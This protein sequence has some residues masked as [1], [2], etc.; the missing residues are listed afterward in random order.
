LGSRTSEDEVDVELGQVD[1]LWR[2]ESGGQW[3]RQ[4]FRGEVAGIKQMRSA[5]QGES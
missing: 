5:M 4:W 3:C 2:V 1:G